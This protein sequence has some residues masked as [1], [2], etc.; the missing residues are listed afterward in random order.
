MTARKIPTISIDLR[1]RCSRCRKPGVIGATG[2]C[3]A[4]A[5]PLILKSVRAAKET[6]AVTLDPTLRE[7]IFGQWRYHYGRDRKA[8][9][10]E[11]TMP[12]GIPI[13]AWGVVTHLRERYCSKCAELAAKA[14][15]A[16]EKKPC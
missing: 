12:S 3:L 2:L 15:A 9:C 4:C 16:E 5:T 14:E 6:E 1:K 8:L 13:S 10:G 7:G 11:A